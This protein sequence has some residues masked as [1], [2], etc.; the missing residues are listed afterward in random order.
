MGGQQTRP[1]INVTEHQQKFRE[2]A[3]ECQNGPV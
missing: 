1:N 3:R 2:I